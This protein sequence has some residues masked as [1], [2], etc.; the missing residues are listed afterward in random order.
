MTARV[1]PWLILKF[2][3]LSVL[4]IL[5]FFVPF[6]LNGKNTIA[7]DHLVT[8]ATSPRYLP[9]ATAYIGVIVLAGCT[10]AVTTGKWRTSA[11]DA[12][13]TSLKLLAIPL[14]AFHL[15]NIGPDFLREPDML[16][17]LFNK[18]A[19]QV[20]VIIPIGA[21]FLVFL[22]G[23]GLLEFCG[24][25][26]DRFMRPIF[27]TPGRSAIDAVASFAGS[28]SIALLLTDKV[29]RQ[30]NYSPREAAIIATGFSTVS[31]PFMVVVAKTL[32]LMPHWSA[33]FWS[34]FL[35]TFA[36]TAITARLWPL[37][38]MSNERTN[39]DDFERDGAIS[40]GR[41]FRIG[42]DTAEQAT[43]LPKALMT[44]LIDGLKM[45]AGVV[46]TILSVGLLGLL[47][48]RYTPVFD[49]IGYLF[50]P[51]A[52]ISGLTDPL[53]TSSAI[54]SGFAE[55]FLPALTGTGAP[56]HSRLV[57]AI[58]SISSVLF[59]SASIPCMLATSIPLRFRH[60]VV[61]WFL[62][63]LLSIPLASA[64]AWLILAQ[65]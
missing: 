11:F 6:T 56:V 9:F 39:P 24:V 45:A 48:A 19:L 42:L 64:C 25:L 37:A 65:F 43:S 59:L 28:Y 41:A 49:W 35:V 27:R 10:L 17:F 8:M 44:G 12:L 38:G 51:A 33:F 58:V 16:P 32:D 31:T 4:G 61:I 63:T 36:V 29:Y 7:L 21:V 2:A 57:I 40:I 46:P 47:A 55:M 18:L 22:T 53:A 5:L 50:Y 1:S 52:W 13:L 26:L 60:L 15:L 14:L 3:G 20:G 30:G 34:T 54:A 62:R 23:Y